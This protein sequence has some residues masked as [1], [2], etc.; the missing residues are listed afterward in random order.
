M[1]AGVASKFY[2]ATWWTCCMT[3]ITCINGVYSCF[4][5]TDKQERWAAKVMNDARHWKTNP[6]Q[7]HQRGHERALNAAMR[8]NGGCNALDIWMQ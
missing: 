1:T 5:F 3:G 6:A 8:L 4:E 2:T 7:C